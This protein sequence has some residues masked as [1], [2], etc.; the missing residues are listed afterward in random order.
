MRG[1]GFY[2]SALEKGSRTEQAL[3][4]ALAEMYVHG[5]STRKV[6]DILVKHL[7][8]E[9]SIS[10]TPVS[11]AA[12]KLDAGFAARRERPLDETPDLFLNAR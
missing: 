10:S 6:C 9:V 7:E 4:L 12:E 8:P 1:G 5:V 2:P 3:N 11:R